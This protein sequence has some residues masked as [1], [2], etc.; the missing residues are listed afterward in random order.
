MYLKFTKNLGR[1]VHFSNLHI[2]SWFVDEKYLGVSLLF[3]YFINGKFHFSPKF[4]WFV[5]FMKQF[6]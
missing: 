5:N 1:L 4:F 6:I 2:E 3:M